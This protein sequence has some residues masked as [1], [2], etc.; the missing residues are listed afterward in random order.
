MFYTGTG[1]NIDTD[2]KDRDNKSRY[3]SI[4]NRDIPKSNPFV[5]RVYQINNSIYND[6][7]YMSDSN[8]TDSDL[9]E[10]TN[11]LIKQL[12]NESDIS[13][14]N[15]S[16][17]VDSKALSIGAGKYVYSDNFKTLSDK[18]RKAV[19]TPLLSLESSTNITLSTSDVKHCIVYT[20][21]DYDGFN[22][23][24]V[25]YLLTKTGL[26]DLNIGVVDSFNYV[27]YFLT[28]DTKYAKGYYS[29]LRYFDDVPKNVLTKLNQMDNSLIYNVL[30][31][32]RKYGTPIN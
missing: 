22:T 12:A 28:R 5:D 32:Y 29:L 30:P 6:K 31:Y 23:I 2:D 21:L 14:V 27:N 13:K 16:V 9:L 19:L 20:R 11:L 17:L 15:L 18:Y 7:Y 24:A 1:N 25:I 3:Y 10:L 26:V 8:I 4:L